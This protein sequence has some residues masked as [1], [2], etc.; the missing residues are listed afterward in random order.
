M[1]KAKLPIMILISALVLLGNASAQTELKNS[2]KEASDGETVDE[3][4]E[5]IKL[6]SQPYKDLR[7]PFTPQIPIT[8]IEEVEKEPEDVDLADG[9][10]IMEP[11]GTE[12]Q[13]A[14]EEEIPPI[15]GKPSLLISGMIWNSDRPQAIVNGVIVEVGDRIFNVPTN[16]DEVITEL[17][18]VDI[19]KDGIAVSFEDRIV[20]LQSEPILK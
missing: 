15:A 7:N 18:F 17:E 6:T 5:F 8:F 4:S 10:G 13:T 12:V 16:M 19:S 9:S 11:T 20:I 1:Y 14:A 2:D 3:M